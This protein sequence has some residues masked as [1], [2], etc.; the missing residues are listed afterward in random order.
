[1]RL[2]LVDDFAPALIV[3]DE[4]VD[5]TGALQGLEAFAERVRSRRLPTST[6]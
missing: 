6:P 3:G 2:A 5:V 4:V 1:M